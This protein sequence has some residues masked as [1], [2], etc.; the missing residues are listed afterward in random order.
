MQEAFGL[1]KQGEMSH[2]VIYLSCVPMS[3]FSM[4]AYLIKKD[5]IYSAN[6]VWQEDL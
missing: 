3:A 2:V 4:S 6:P 1:G 5:V